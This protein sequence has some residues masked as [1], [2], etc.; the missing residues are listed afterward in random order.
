MKI[1]TYI[2]EK[3]LRR[4]LKESGAASQR[5]VLELGLHQLLADIKRKQFVKNFSQLHLSL[6]LDQLKQSRA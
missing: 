3:L 1:T 5:E 2:D 4:G 6:T